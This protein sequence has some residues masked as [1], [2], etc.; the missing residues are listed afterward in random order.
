MR[1]RVVFLAA[2]VL[3]FL[4]GF[5]GCEKKKP[6]PPI[7]PES[8]AVIKV[9]PQRHNAYREFVTVRWPS[10]EEST[11]RLKTGLCD[12]GETYPKCSEG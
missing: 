3:P 1:K 7:A 8:G 10:G 9:V 4:M 2:M 5:S 11:V 12:V 6:A